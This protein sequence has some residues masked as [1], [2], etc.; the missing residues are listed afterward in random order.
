[1]ATTTSDRRVLVSG[2]ARGRSLINVS[3][4]WDYSSKHA[5][6]APRE[7]FFACANALPEI[8]EQWRNWDFLMSH[9]FMMC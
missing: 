1:M 3:S 4:E 7:F 5:E 6:R 2:R 8:R 9:D